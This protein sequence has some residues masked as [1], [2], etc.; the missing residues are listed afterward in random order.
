[1]LGRNCSHAKN[2]WINHLF[3]H[4][5]FTIRQRWAGGKLAADSIRKSIADGG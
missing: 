1:M 3:L 5:N 4:E 2:A